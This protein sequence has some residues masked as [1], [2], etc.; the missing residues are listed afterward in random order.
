MKKLLTLGFTLIELLIVIA[1]LGVLAAG[2]L[3][4]INPLDRVNSAK[5]SQVQKDITALANAAEQ[6]GAVHEGRYPLNTA[7]MLSSGELK[8]IPIPPRGYSSYAYVAASCDAI[9]CASFTLVG[10]L[11]SK[12]YTND[13]YTVFRYDSALGKSC[14]WN[15]SSCQ[16]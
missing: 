3:I 14:P 7:T 15:G 6:Y 10:D 8:I 11:K 4:A 12:K 5:D 2:V 13:G 9:D 16:P 1:V